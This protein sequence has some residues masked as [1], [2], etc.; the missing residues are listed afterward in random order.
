MQS[1]KLWLVTAK[2]SRGYGLPE[3]DLMVLAPNAARATEKAT[4][5]IKRHKYFN[6]K[7][8]SVDYQGEID[9]F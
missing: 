9:I 7:I 3:G 6:Y 8:T 4:K 1:S 2:N 5:W